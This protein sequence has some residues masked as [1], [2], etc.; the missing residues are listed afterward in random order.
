MKLSEISEG[1]LYKTQEVAD[2]LGISRAWL[3][4]LRRRGE[5][6]SIGSRIAGYQLLEFLKKETK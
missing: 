1:K 3:Y 2:M 6:K 4:V 5:I